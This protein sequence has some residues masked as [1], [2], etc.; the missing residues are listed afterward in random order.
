MLVLLLLLLLLGLLLAVLPLVRLALV[1]VPRPI[2][3]I[4]TS[5]TFAPMPATA[6]LIVAVVA[7]WSTRRGW[8]WRST[9]MIMGRGVGSS[10]RVVR[11]WLRVGAAHLRVLCVIIRWYRCATPTTTAIIVS[12]SSPTAAPL[13]RA[14][15]GVVLLTTPLCRGTGRRWGSLVLRGVLLRIVIPRLLS[16]RV[17]VLVAGIV[18][19]GLRVLLRRPLWL[20]RRIA[21]GRRD[22]GPS[23]VRGRVVIL[24][25]V[26]VVGCCCCCC[27]GWGLGGLLLLVAAVL[28]VVIPTAAASTTRS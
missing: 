17:R 2:S 6:A 11:V 14:G 18:G 21:A 25:R 10:M 4:L 3:E 7:I 16:L 24:G 23:S 26:V 12:A 27:S 15:L 20:G 5:S 28:S 1:V 9:V 13:E 19:G 22:L 8:R